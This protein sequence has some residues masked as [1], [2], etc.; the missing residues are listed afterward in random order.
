MVEVRSNYHDLFYEQENL[1][2]LSGVDMQKMVAEDR[3]GAPVTGFSM[4]NHMSHPR[5]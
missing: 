3:I 2:H 4:H 1:D 5:T